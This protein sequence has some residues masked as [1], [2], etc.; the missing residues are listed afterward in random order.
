M[1]IRDRDVTGLLERARTAAED[2]VDAL[3]PS[4]TLSADAILEA[5]TTAVDGTGVTAAWTTAYSLEPALS[6]IHLY[7]VTMK[8][9]I[10]NLN[11]TV[12]T[13]ST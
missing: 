1:C 10:I 2:A 11:L 5:V 12:Y 13:I 4:N 6:L 8:H 3:T 9:I 7:Q